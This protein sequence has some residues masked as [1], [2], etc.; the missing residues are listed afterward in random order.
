MLLEFSIV[1]GTPETR[2]SFKQPLRAESGTGAFHVET[3]WIEK[4]RKLYKEHRLSLRPDARE[5]RMK[6]RHEISAGGALVALKVGGA[7]N[8]GHV[9]GESDPNVGVTWSLLYESGAFRSSS[10]SCVRRR[11]GNRMR[12][13]TGTG[14]P[15]S[16]A[17]RAHA[18]PTG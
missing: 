10:V 2:L 3:G 13:A 12:E 4:R 6:L 1:V 7:L 16:S 18:D 8:S 14:N 15:A 11:P 9:P 5:T 17:Q